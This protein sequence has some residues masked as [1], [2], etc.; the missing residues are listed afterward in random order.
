MKSLCRSIRNTSSCLP[1]FLGVH[2]CDQDDIYK[3]LKTREDFEA[4]LTWRLPDFGNGPLL[5]SENHL[6][7]QA[8]TTG[9]RYGNRE[10]RVI[11]EF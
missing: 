1:K 10:L 5:I 4:C 8:Y 6:S 11:N 9:M 3:I 2:E 7:G